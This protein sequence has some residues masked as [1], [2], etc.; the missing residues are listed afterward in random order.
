MPCRVGIT[1]KPEERRRYW[2]GKVVGLSNWEK[3]YFGSKTAAQNEENRRSDYCNEFQNRGQCH[4]NPGGGEPDSYGW[5]V[6]EF[7]YIR[8]R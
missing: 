8:W 5:Y 7:D 6:Y 2:E 1:T 3:D 4:A